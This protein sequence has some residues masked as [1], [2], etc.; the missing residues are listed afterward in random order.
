VLRVDTPPVAFGLTLSQ[1]VSVLLLVGGL[2]LGAIVW[3][4]PPQYNPA[5]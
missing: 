2:V 1:N 4:R 5:T 3:R